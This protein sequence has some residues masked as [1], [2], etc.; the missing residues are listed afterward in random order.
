LTIEFQH[1]YISEDDRKRREDFW[2]N[3]VWVVNGN[4]TQSAEY[5]FKD[6]LSLGSLVHPERQTY[7]VDIGDCELVRL[8]AGSTVPVYFDF[9]ANGFWRMAAEKRGT[10]A[11]LTPVDRQEFIAAATDGR[12]PRSSRKIKTALPTKRRRVARQ[13]VRLERSTNPF[14]EGWEKDFWARRGIWR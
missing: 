3:M 5:Y 6:M 14:Y 13:K 4:R 1:S 12:E 2:S 11:Y 9:G 10:L 8:W 7:E